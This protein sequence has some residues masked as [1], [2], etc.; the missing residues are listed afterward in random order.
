MQSKPNTGRKPAGAKSGNRNR[1][2]GEQP[3]KEFA[4]TRNDNTGKPNE[5]PRKQQKPRN[6]QK[7]QNKS[8]EKVQT[9]Q[10]AAAPVKKGFLA[11]LTGLFKGKK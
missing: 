9:N 5:K 4:G 8:A 7:P 3:R 11:K 6:Y 2:G 1:K 10:K